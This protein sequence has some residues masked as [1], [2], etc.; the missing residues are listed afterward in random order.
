MTIF[1]H[2]CSCTWE[3]NIP[4]PLFCNPLF[5]TRQGTVDAEQRVF[6]LL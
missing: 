3:F 6:F 1:C 2:A 5:L 4:P